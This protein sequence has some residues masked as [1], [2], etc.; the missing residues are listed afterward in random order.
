M[1]PGPQRVLTI[2]GDSVWVLKRMFVIGIRRRG[3]E[4]GCFRIGKSTNRK[5]VQN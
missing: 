4:S 3:A 2:Q 1:G 5:A